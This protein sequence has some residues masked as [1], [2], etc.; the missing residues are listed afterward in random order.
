MYSIINKYDFTRA[1]EIMGRSDQFSFHG[2]QALYE[3]LEEV[4]ED[5]NGVELDVVALCCEWTQYKSIEEYNE[6]YETEYESYEELDDEGVCE[7]IHVEGDEFICG[8]H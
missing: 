3:W 8:E 7:V 6:A 5:D 4:Y 1:F 2:L